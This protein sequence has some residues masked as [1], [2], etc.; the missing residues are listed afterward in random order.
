MSN[1]TRSYRPYLTEAEIEYLLSLLPKTE[2]QEKI[3]EFARLSVVEKLSLLQFKIQ[4]N[5]TS[6][7]YT[8]TPA[9]TTAEKLGFA[10][11]GQ[12]MTEKATASKEVL[13]NSFALLAAEGECSE[14]DR[15]RGLELELELFGFDSGLFS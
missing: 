6:P 13:Y 7:A 15:K 11:K 8:A 9:I 4:R 10:E 2:E 1:T 3:R 12:K 5:I 14:E